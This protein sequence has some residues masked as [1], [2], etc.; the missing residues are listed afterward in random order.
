[1]ARAVATLISVGHA[2]TRTVVTAPDYLRPSEAG[3]AMAKQWRYVP[4]MRDCCSA[5][6]EGE[7]LQGN[8]GGTATADRR[9]N[10]CGSTR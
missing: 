8:V 10:L 2:Q 3:A 5:A 4:R 6:S 7:L 1:M 9:G